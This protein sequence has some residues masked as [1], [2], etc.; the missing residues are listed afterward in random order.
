MKKF[1]KGAL[2]TCLI[3]FLT[4]II[5]IVGGVAAAGPKAFQDGFKSV[6]DSNWFHINGWDWTFHNGDDWDSNTIFKGETKDF[7][8]EKSQV[9][10]LNVDSAYGHLDIKETNSDHIIV[11]ITGKK[12]STKYSCELKNGELLIKGNSKIRAINLGDGRALDIVIMIP[13]SLQLNKMNLNF[14]AGDVTVNLPKS[15]IENT[16]LDVDAGDLTV[17]SL[18][19]T[20]LKINIGAGEMDADH[21]NTKTATIECGMGDVTVEH[22]T[23]T[24]KLVASVG[25]GEITMNL[26]GNKND[27]NYEISCGMGN[28]SVGD[29]SYSGLSND[30]TIDNHA[31]VDVKLDCGMG[32][33][34]VNFD[35]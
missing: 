28:L 14:A 31:Q 25:M 9:K 18:N 16:D 32:N 12:S 20:D 34:E 15:K 8:F 7:S 26:N 27:Y 21:L 13:E 35:K 29:Q 6:V 3:L 22:L 23:V 5:V 10:E 17:S 11:K 30:A 19:S 4:A 24:E 1:T 2:I 33:L